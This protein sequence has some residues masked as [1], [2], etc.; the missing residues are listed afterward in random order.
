MGYIVN[1]SFTGMH[2]PATIRASVAPGRIP[3]SGKSPGTTYTSTEE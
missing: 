1:E 3:D 2:A